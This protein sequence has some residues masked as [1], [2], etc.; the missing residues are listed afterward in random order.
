MKRTADTVDWGP[1][2]IPVS[3]L[4]TLM[5]YV[6]SQILGSTVCLK[7]NMKRYSTMHNIIKSIVFSGVIHEL[8]IGH[9]HALLVS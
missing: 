5:V 6:Y 9:W 1:I 3:M 7:M 2:V 8:T 4:D